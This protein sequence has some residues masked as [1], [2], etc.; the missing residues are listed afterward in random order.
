MKSIHIS[1]MERMRSINLRIGFAAAIVLAI[2]AFNWTTERPA[3]ITFEDEA[4]PSEVTLKPFTISEPRAAEQPPSTVLKPQDIIIEVPDLVV[5]GLLP[6][7]IPTDSSSVSDE[8]PGNVAAAAPIIP[9]APP[10]PP[11]EDI[12]E[13]P[14]I[15]IAEEMPRFPGCEDMDLSKSERTECATNRLLKFIYE[16]IRYP[17]IARQNGI[18][19]TVYIKFVVEKDGSISNANIVRDIG[20]GC[21]QEAMRVVGKMPKWQPGKQRGRAVRVQFNLPVKF[22]LS[23]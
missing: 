2:F 10:L 20:G 6:S 23:T 3:P 15:L 21:G 11:E 16:N 9:K 18:E 22:K 17:D 7:L 5:S 13:E 14:W 4:Y 12:K 19:G 1:K 8:E